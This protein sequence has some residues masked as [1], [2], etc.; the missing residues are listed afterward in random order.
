MFAWSKTVIRIPTP[1]LAKLSFFGRPPF[2]ALDESFLTA[3]KSKK[4]K[5]V[6]AFTALFGGGEM[7]GR[8]LLMR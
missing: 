2:V 7:H 5:G 8:S 3:P 1:V 4:A 6:T